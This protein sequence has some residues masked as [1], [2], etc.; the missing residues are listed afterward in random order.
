[1]SATEQRRAVTGPVVFVDLAA[2]H[3]EVEAEVAEGFARVMGATAFIGGPDVARFE[4]SWAAYTGTRH[5]IGVANGT[6]ALEL[7]MRALGIG[8]GDEVIV[9]TNSFVAS[10]VAVARAGARPTFVD[11]DP[12]HLLIDPDR[13]SD[14]INE[15]TRAIMPVHLYGQIAPME[16]I[17]PIAAR[18]GLSIVEDAAQCHGATRHGQR[19]GAWGAAAATSFYPGKNL[20]AYGDAGGVA[21]NDDALAGTLAAIRNY[22]S[23]HKYEHP[24]LGFNSRLD[25]LQAVVLAAKLARL[26]GWNDARREAAA[27]YDALL[28]EVAGVVRPAV[29]PGNEAVWHLYVVQVDDRDGVLARLQEAGVQA[30]IHYPVPI[31][32]QGAFAELGYGPGDFPVAEQ[33]AGRILSLPMHP[34]LSAPHQERVV[35]ALVAALR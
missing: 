5:A 31:H 35:E 21:T 11:C 7:A 12:L 25:T 33:A 10:A 20:G 29:L 24:E 27:R 3:R 2:Q 14:A 16:A 15:R 28:A 17:V 32:L 6:D 9:P 34:H 18:A 22:G 1:V 26:D 4:R 30:G 23:V 8:P 19:A 13:I